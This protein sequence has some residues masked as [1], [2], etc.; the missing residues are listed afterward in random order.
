M[1]LAVISAFTAFLV[2]GST[3]TAAAQS[4]ITQT[5]IQ[6][7]ENAIYDTARDV[8]QLRNR[9]ATL[10]NRLQTDLDDA[11]DEAIYLKVKLRKN[12]TVTRSDYR[13]LSD[14]IDTIRAQA[15]G[16]ST[17]SSSRDSSRESGISDS[18]STA[19]RSTAPG[20]VPAGTEFDVKLTRGLNSGTA[21]VEDR[22]EATTLV[23]LMQGDRVL[24]P[25]G[26]T[27]RGVVTSVNKAGRVERKGSLTVSFDQ[28]N[29]HGRT[30]PITA[31]VTQALE[32]EG[33]KGEV[34]KIGAG[35]GVGAII[36]GIIGGFKGAMVGILIGG[37]GT[38]AATEG[39]DVDLPAGT[40]LRV[41]LDSSLNVR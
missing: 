8:T 40:I 25:A 16:D 28:M 29:V 24:V 13:E 23:D 33:V 39:K 1:R 6:R 21:Q 31:T 19:S 34:A 27:M 35:A 17:R 4:S 14:R 5:D 12:E 26:S 9:D 2:A 36:G 20:E 32:S 18:P 15:R 7:L 38:I 37:G 11:R 41:R 10:A 30:Y 3:P 22:V